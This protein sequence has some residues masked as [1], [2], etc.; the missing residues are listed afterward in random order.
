MR[1]RYLALG[2]F[3]ALTV[4]GLFACSQTAINTALSSPPGQLFC[5]I[6]TSGGGSFVAGAVDAEATA[7]SPGLSPVAIIATGLAKDK[8][9]ADCASAGKNAGGV[10]TAVSPPLNPA[11]APLVA[12]VVSAVQASIKP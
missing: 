11:A 9:D 5:A 10:G 12:V 6:Q 1:A 7:L 2:A 8:V 4:I 3:L